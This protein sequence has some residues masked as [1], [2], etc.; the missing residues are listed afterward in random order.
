MLPDGGILLAYGNRNPPYRIEGL[1]SRDGGHIWSDELCWAEV[2]G[3]VGSI[4]D[5]RTGGVELPD[6]TLAWLVCDGDMMRGERVRLVHSWDRGA[7]WA[8]PTRCSCPMVRS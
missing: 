6:G 5:W 4:C 8:I 2:E 3:A 7:T 1:V